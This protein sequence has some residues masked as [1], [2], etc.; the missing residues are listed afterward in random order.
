MTQEKDLPLGLVEE[1]L[2]LVFSVADGLATET[3]YGDI[4][5]LR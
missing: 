2:N 1:H 4:I 5:G 3:F